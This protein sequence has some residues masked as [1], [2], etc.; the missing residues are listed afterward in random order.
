L[1]SVSLSYKLPTAW[2]GKYLNSAGIRLEA[3]NLFVITDY[4]GIDP[5]TDAYTA[6]YPNVKTYTL[7]IDLK[8]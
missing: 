2:A 8:F 4:K 6:A 1:Q 5:E 3:Q 7:G